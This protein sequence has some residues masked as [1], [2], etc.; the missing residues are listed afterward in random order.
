MNQNSERLDDVVQGGRRRCQAL[1]TAML[2]Q[3]V[4]KKDM[5][6]H[7]FFQIKNIHDRLAHVMSSCLRLFLFQHVHH[8]TMA[9]TA[10]K[11]ASIPTMLTGTLVA[12]PGNGVAPV[13]GSPGAEVEDEAPAA[14]AAPLDTGVATE[15]GILMVEKAGIAA[16][17]EVG[18]GVISTVMGAVATTV[19]LALV[20]PTMTTEGSDAVLLPY[21]VTITWEVEVDVVVVVGSVLPAA[22]VETTEVAV[23]VLWTVSKE[24]RVCVVV[25]D[26]VSAAAPSLLGEGNGKGETMTEEVNGMTVIGTG[27]TDVVTRAGQLMTDAGHSVTVTSTMLNEVDV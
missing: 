18:S 11:A 20:G 7:G 3:Y 12:A 16:L 23:T 22:R 25:S 5:S 9:A 24:I 21:K 27:I 15:T 14:A 17:V 8:M 4:Q 1:D 6:R 26:V 13:L 19:V 10:P 2:V